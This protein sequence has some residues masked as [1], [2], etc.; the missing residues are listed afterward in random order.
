MPEHI[1]R[2]QEISKMFNGRAR[3]FYMKR[4][5][6]DVAQSID[7]FGHNFN[8]YGNNDCK[9]KALIDFVLETHNLAGLF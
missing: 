3:F 7:S 5:W 9:W 8:W 6:I 2:A 4:N 1:L